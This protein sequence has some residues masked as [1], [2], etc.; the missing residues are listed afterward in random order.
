LILFCIDYCK[1]TLLPWNDPNDKKNGSLIW[2]TSNV[3]AENDAKKIAYA[4]LLYSK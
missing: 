3:G 4:E 2:G 1:L